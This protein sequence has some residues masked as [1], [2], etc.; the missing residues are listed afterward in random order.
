MLDRKKE[1]ELEFTRRL[2]RE[3]P[4]GVKG[5]AYVLM[6]IRRAI[7]AGIVKGATSPVK[8]GG[9]NKFAMMFNKAATTR[10][11]HTEK[12]KELS[13]ML[14]DQSEKILQH[15]IKEQAFQ[16]EESIVEKNEIFLE[17]IIAGQKNQLDDFYLSLRGRMEG[18]QKEIDIVSNRVNVL[19]RNQAEQN[20]QRN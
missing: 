9:I 7:A 4:R 3:D 6:E 17:R 11:Q 18:M 16:N 10:L 2:V 14:K 8:N 5:L 20:E 19:Q 12:N 13:I 15:L 1:T